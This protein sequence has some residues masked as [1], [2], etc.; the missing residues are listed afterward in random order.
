MA[1]QF[2]GTL[3]PTN[4]FTAKVG[5]GIVYCLEETD[6]ELQAG[7]QSFIPIVFNLFANVTAGDFFTLHGILFTFVAGAPTNANEIQ[8]NG[9]FT[10]ANV[11][12]ALTNFP[13]FVDNYTITQPNQFEIHIEAIVAQLDQDYGFSYTTANVNAIQINPFYPPASITAGLDAIVKDD[14]NV[15]LDVYDVLAGEVKVCSISNCKPLNVFFDGS[16]KVCFDVQKIIEDYGNIYSNPP[17][18]L[19]TVSSGSQDWDWYSQKFIGQ[20]RFRFTSSYQNPNNV[21]CERVIGTSIKEPASLGL[22][23]YVINIA[24]EPDSDYTA[25]DF[26]FF[27]APSLPILPLTIH[28]DDYLLCKDVAWEWLVDLP[29][30]L[31][32]N[33]FGGIAQLVLEYG[34]TDGST[35][36]H[37]LTFSTNADGVQ[38]ISMYLGYTIPAADPTKTLSLIQASVQYSV[39]AMPFINVANKTWYFS[40]TGEYC[41]KCHKQFYFL[42]QLGNNEI[43]IARCDFQKDFEITNFQSYQE[44][45]CGGDVFL[46]TP[47]FGGGNVTINTDNESELHTVLIECQ[48]S[49]Y[50][51][52]FLKSTTK[53]VYENEKLYRVEQTANSYKIYQVNDNRFLMQFQYRKSIDSVRRGLTN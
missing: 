38:T 10:A 17:A 53:Y 16:N 2:V 14:Y 33:V 21:A 29:V 51:K 22:R 1:L 48:N 25:T 44:F 23:L 32:M 26:S 6:Y 12:A 4:E 8:V 7:V 34:Y 35:D 43:I 3:P 40:T 15:C 41:C 45:T 31:I 18:P 50:L 52:A 42:S 37:V 13:F 36:T 19:P 27:G 28:P 5:C 9:L 20:F 11:F 46:D 47:V 24:I 49:D 30:D 39:M